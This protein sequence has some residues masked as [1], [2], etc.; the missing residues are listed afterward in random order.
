[1]IFFFN[2]KLVLILLLGVEQAGQVNLS[3]F[4]AALTAHFIIL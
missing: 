4:G 2:M 1:M 3:T